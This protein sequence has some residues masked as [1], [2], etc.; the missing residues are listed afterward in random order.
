MNKKYISNIVFLLL[1]AISFILLFIISRHDY[2]LFHSMIEMFGIVIASGVFMIAYNATGYIRTGF[3]II[4]GVSFFFAA[5]LEFFH[6]LAYKGMGVFS[7]N[8]PNLATQLWIAL[9]YLRAISFLIAPL[10]MNFKIQIRDVFISYF[11][12]TAI[13]FTSIFYLKVFPV[14]FVEGTGLTTFKIGSEYIISFILFISIF[15]VY[16]KR[17]EIDRFVRNLIIASIA[18]SIAAKMMF[19]LY[20]DIYGFLN[21]LGHILEFISYALIYKAVIQTG[22]RKPFDLLFKDLK[23]NE[24]KLISALSEIKTLQSILPI[25]ASC[26][27][28]RNDRGNWQMVEEY[29]SEHTDTKF[30][31]G[32]CQ[33]CAEKLYPNVFK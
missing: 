20:S 15:F 26:K 9:G 8:D 12:V 17:T 30:S 3:F 4:I 13:I 1:S 25:C 23:V 11:L 14:C 28:I 27:K 32:I 33:A 5:F 10:L 18:A 21:F 7:G 19:T 2:L 31:H 22:I 24:E 29:I 16:K 6:M